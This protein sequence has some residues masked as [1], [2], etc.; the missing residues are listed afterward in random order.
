MAGLRLVTLDDPEVHAAD[1]VAVGPGPAPDDLAYVIFTSGSTGRPKGVMIDHRGAANTVQDV[2]ARFGVTPA[3]RV[4]GL[5]ALSFDLSVY[6]V[7]GALAAGAAVVLPAPARAADPEHW[8][9][10][11]RRHRVTVWNSVP[12]LMQAWVDAP[13]A[14]ADPA[15][16]SLRVVMLSGDWIPVRLPDAIRRRHPRAAVHSL[17]GATEASIWSIHFPVGVVD[18]GWASIPYG[19]PM[20]NQTMHVYDD[21]FTPCPVWTPGELW[22]GGTG[23]ALGYWADPVRTDER[24][25][26]HPVTG[27]RLYRTGDLGRWLPDGTIEFLGRDDDQVKLNGF[28]IE[29]G[30]IS[31]AL[32]RL[33]GVAEAVTVVDTN[34]GTGRRQLVGYVVPADPAAPV[35]AETLRAGLARV[36][37]EYMV[38]H[39]YPVLERVPLSANGKVDRGALPSPWTRLAPAG[40]PAA[41]GDDVERT[42]L[43]IWQE[44]LDRDDFGVEDNFFELGADSLHAVRILGRLREEFGI[45]P[46]ADEGLPML[47]DSPTVAEL[48]ETVRGLLRERV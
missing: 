41:P 32:S 7:F 1:P 25:V 35:P 36:L 18:D 6:D 21:R 3:D 30:E 46:D 44:A 12:A 22:I 24:F 14:H 5:S 13:A 4:L 27:E 34:P 42:I 28:R 48:A 40:Q 38:P 15:E 43:A 31:A 10:L 11:V 29:L 26:R 45:E 2:N 23:V 17:G 20:A 16:S 37:P 33:P 47:F 39:H 9:D 19:R 8:S